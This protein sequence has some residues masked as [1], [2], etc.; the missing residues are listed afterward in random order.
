[1]EIP[2]TVYLVVPSCKDPPWKYAVR[3]VYGRIILRTSSRVVL[4]ERAQELTLLAN[5]II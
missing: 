5:Y 3:T 1:M 4:I 2:V